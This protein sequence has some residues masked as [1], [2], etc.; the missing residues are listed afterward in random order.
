MRYAFERLFSYA[1]D[2]L[3]TCSFC[4]RTA[5]RVAVSAWCLALLVASL[6]WSAILSPETISAVV[7]LALIGAVALTM[8]WIA[9]LVVYV[10]K[11]TVAKSR[12]D[13]VQAQPA[14]SR[15]A[16]F[17]LFARA[18]GAAAVMSAVPAFGQD[19]C[20]GGTSA[21]GQFCN[22][23]ERG[24]FECEFSRPCYDREGRCFCVNRGGECD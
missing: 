23:I 13:M 9:H 10:R 12:R 2:N 20:P 11:V 7:P 21:C 22:D 4:I 19:D 17:I 3:G 6:G 24:Q 8:L 16:M 14:V 5:F 15:R 1:W 18:L